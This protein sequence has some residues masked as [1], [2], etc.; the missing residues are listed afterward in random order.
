MVQHHGL[1]NQVLYDLPTLHY[2]ICMFGGGFLHC[3]STKMVEILPNE[4]C[5]DRREESLYQTIR[6]FRVTTIK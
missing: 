3:F 4:N 1:K 6:G 5:Y 2:T